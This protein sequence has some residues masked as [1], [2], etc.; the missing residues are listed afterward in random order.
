MSITGRLL[1][2]IVLV[3]V[4]S[5]VG[6]YIWYH[7]GVRH[8]MVT[9]VLHGAALLAAVGA[10]GVDT[11]YPTAEVWNREAFNLLVEK[12]VRTYTPRHRVIVYEASPFPT[13]DPII[14]KVSMAKL[15]TVGITISSTIYIPPLREVEIDQHMV[16]RLNSISNVSPDE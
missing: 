6:D 9:G 14:C 8:Q 11:F 2:G 10:V 15:G 7:Y 16:S 1:L 5:T 13:C 4:V 3:A 12:L